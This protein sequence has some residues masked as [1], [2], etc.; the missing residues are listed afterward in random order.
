MKVFMYIT[1]L[2]ATLNGVNARILNK[3]E[4]VINDNKLTPVV[5]PLIGSDPHTWSPNNITHNITHCNDTHMTSDL[6]KLNELEQQLVSLYSVDAVLDTINY[7]DDE[8]LP[9]IIQYIISLFIP[10]EKSSVKIY[11]RKALL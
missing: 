1:L 6:N 4:S 8:S 7:K 11:N 10:R 2:F 3:E 5:S 9:Y